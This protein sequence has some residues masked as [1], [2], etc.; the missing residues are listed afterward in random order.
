MAH[1]GDE[2]VHPTWG[3]GRIRAILDG[4]RRWR[5]AF[6]SSPSMPRTIQAAELEAVARPD[7]P[8]LEF[9]APAPAL[10]QS[11]EAL[12]LGV[13]PTTGLDAIT[14]ARDQELSRIRGL[15]QAGR[16]MLLLSGGYGTGKTHLVE[17]AEAEALAANLLVARATFDPEEVPPSHPLRL[18]RAL[19]QGLRYPGGT[20]VGLRPLLERL[21]GSQI[22]ADPGGAG[23]H[24]YLSPVLWAMNQH[25]DE[26]VIDDLLGFVQAQAWQAN[27]TLNRALSRQGWRGDSLLALPDYRTFGQVMAHL[28][29]GVAVWAR[30]A[31]FRGLLVLAD[32]AEYLDQLESTSRD[33]ATNVLKYLAMAT[34]PTASLAFD[35]ASV[36]RG[37]QQIH[38]QITPIFAQDQPLSAL[39]AFTPHPAIRDVL[40]RIVADPEVTLALDPVPPWELSRLAD[41]ILVL[42]QQAYPQVNPT[43]EHRRAITGQ[44]TGAFRRGEVETTR[45]AARLVVEFWD[46][47]RL[48]P[49]R[50]LKAL[51]L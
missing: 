48:R 27:D 22:H 24:R 18:Y 42:Y 21:S 45:Q 26:E 5:V 29:G 31:G 43:D 9:K 11:L 46:L 32:E 1:I 44:L 13:V 12:R 41:R 4:G 8:D 20:G 33:M 2:V 7:L 3:P 39:C 38:R 35:P 36:Y 50:A 40:S 47:Y 49:D 16:G 14:V 37:G 23:Y 15:V 30:D 19:M 34:L 51:G 6:Q 28:L 10:R 25:M 17:I